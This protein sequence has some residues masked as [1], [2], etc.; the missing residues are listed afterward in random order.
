M[1]KPPW[2]QQW[3]GLNEDLFHNLAISASI[4]HFQLNPNEP[5]NELICIHKSKKCTI[6]GRYQPVFLKLCKSLVKLKIFQQSAFI[7]IKIGK[8]INLSHIGQLILT[9]YNALRKKTMFAIWSSFLGENNQALFR[10]IPKRPKLK[11]LSVHLHLSGSHPVLRERA[12]HLT[13]EPS[14]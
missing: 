2:L 4:R 8:Q 10:K 13:T 12:F 5:K 6:I 14:L 1:R 9:S 11:F 3:T 7:F